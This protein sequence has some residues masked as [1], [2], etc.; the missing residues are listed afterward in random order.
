MEHRYIY[1]SNESR[2][3]R[4]LCEGKEYKKL[5]DTPDNDS[6]I[7]TIPVK[8]DALYLIN[9]RRKDAPRLTVEI[10]DA[11]VVRI[12]DEDGNEITYEENGL[13]YSQ[14]QI[15]YHLGKI[16]STENI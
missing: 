2:Y 12:V 10:V 7:E 4:Y 11:E 1:P 9:G 8:Y 3:V 5:Y 14:C 15:W 6:P 16:I 13:V